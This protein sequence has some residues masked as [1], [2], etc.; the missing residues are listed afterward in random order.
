MVNYLP[1][2]KMPGKEDEVSLLTASDGQIARDLS[3]ASEKRAPGRAMAGGSLRKIPL[4]CPRFRLP[5]CGS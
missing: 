3:P 4:V 2:P 5:K 1:C